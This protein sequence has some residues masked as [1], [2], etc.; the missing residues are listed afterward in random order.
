MATELISLAAHREAPCWSRGERR[1]GREELPWTDPSE[2]E[3][4]L[5]QS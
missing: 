1:C 2:G 5:K 3:R 4:S